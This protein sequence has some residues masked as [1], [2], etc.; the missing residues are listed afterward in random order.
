MKTYKWEVKYDNQSIGKLFFT[1]KECK[2]EWNTLWNR[3]L[4]GYTICKINN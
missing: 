3:G 1:K 4:Y 2:Q